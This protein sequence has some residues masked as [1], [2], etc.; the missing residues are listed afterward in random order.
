MQEQEQKQAQA[1]VLRG[2]SCRHAW[3]EH[4]RASIATALQGVLRTYSCPK[5]KSG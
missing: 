3:K 4:C 5:G 2:M 1:Q